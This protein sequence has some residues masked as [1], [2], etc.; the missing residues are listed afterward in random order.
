MLYRLESLTLKPAHINMMEKTHRKFLRA[1]QALLVRVATPAIYLLL[2]ELT[3]EARLHIQTLV[4]LQ[5]V[6]ADTQSLLHRLAV[7]SMSTKDS[8]IHGSAM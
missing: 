5:A 7:K 4:F 8:H 6:I 3:L 2:G 1:I